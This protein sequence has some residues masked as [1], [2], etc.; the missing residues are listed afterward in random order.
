MLFIKQKCN[1]CMKLHDRTTQDAKKDNSAKTLHKI[2]PAAE[3]YS[4]DCAIVFH[5]WYKYCIA[6]PVIGVLPVC[7][8]LR[9]PLKY[10]L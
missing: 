4:L 6:R 9:T 5:F 8:E 1:T 3:N 10:C 7:R 2:K